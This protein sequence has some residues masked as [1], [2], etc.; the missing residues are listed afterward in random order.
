MTN[1][2]RS[3]IAVLARTGWTK[4]AF[5]DD[6]G[7]HCLQGA[8]YDAYGLCPSRVTGELA[9]DVRLLNQTIEEQYP[10]RFGAVGISRFNDHPETTLEDVIRVLEKAAVRKDEL[11]D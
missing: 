1:H 6:N 5:T 9:A 11:L 10:E 2:I 3:A 7:Q 8:L 4:H